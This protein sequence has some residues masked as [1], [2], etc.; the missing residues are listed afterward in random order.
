[1]IP[2]RTSKQLLRCTEGYPLDG[3]GPTTANK[4]YACGIRS[5]DDFREGTKGYSL[6]SKQQKIGLKYYDEFNM[7][8]PREEVQ[9]RELTT[10]SN[11]LFGIGN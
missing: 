5:L 7:K 8:I 9:V 11:I 10:A 2:V 1:M 3:T 4:W 6:L